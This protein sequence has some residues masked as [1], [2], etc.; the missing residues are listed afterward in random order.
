M[1]AN[2]EGIQDYP[3]L[4]GVALLYPSLD[5]EQVA[6]LKGVTKWKIKWDDIDDLETV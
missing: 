5:I 3:V 2:A 6:S 1:E 4:I